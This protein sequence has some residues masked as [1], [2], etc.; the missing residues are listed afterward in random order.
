MQLCLDSKDNLGP[1][2]DWI[3]CCVLSH[4]MLAQLGDAWDEEFADDIEEIL[5][6]PELHMDVNAGVQ[7]DDLGYLRRELV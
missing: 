7:D 1:Y 5:D 3:L 2:I 6:L 4:N